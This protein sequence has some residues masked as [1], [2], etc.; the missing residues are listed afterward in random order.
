M[1]PRSGRSPGPGIRSS[2]RLTE[3]AR[4]EL[5]R[6]APELG[7][8]PEEPSAEGRE[9]AQRQLFDALGAL[10]AAL[11]EDEPVL[12][13]LEDLHWADRSTRAF[14]VYLAR[15]LRSERVLVVSTYRS[16]ELHRRHPLRPLLAELE[17]A[18]ATRRIELERFGRDELRTQLVDITGGEPEEQVLERLFA[19][20]EG[21]P[22]FA[23]EL[24]A[25]GL[26]ARGAPPPTLRDALLLRTDRLSPEAQRQLRLLAVAG[27]ADDGLLAELSA[28]ST[29]E[30]REALREA[31]AAN[32]VSAGADGDLGFRHA[33]LRE[34]VYDDLLPGERA[35]L[36]LQLGRALEERGGDHR[37]LAAA[38]AHH[39][40]AAEAQ[41]DALRTAVAAAEDA[42]GVNAFG[43]ASALFDRAL[44][45]WARVADPEQLAR[46]DHVELIVRAARA[47][48]Y[49]RDDSRAIALLEQAATELDAE[50]EPLRLASVLGELASGQWSMG[51]ADTGRATLHRALELAGSEPSPER[52]RVL[53]TQVRLRLLQG[54]FGEVEEVAA[55]ALETADGRR[56][57]L[58]PR[59]RPAPARLRGL[60]QR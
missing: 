60:R 27:R 3:P 31:V 54:R 29:E 48:F 22:L 19:R 38:V 15:S 56:A 42:E 44:S 17:R 18:P 25:A 28:A 33:L 8:P 26:D 50:T 34:V 5:A 4:C 2:R 11:A 20:S 14:V 40:D 35:E 52:A 41:P 32:V 30:V 43:E 59:R 57:R 6:L 24:L 12:L 45:L 51:D 47:N 39:Y 1:P 9:E 46:C 13:W 23:E 10:L 16:D 55:E 53:A 7:T 37:W 49:A 21:N 58:G 36:H